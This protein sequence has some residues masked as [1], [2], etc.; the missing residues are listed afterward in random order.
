[1]PLLSA[2][3]PI[4]LNVISKTANEQKLNSAD[5]A[6]VLQAD[7]TATSAS[8]KPEVQAM[9]NEAVHI[10]DQA[11]RLRSTFTDDE[12]T[13]IRLAPLATTYYV[14]SASA[15]GVVG[16]TKE[17]LAAGDAM[18]TLVKDARPT[19]LVDVAFGSLGKL[20]ADSTLDKQSPRDSLVITL[21]AATAAVKA[22]SPADAKS[23]GD[24]L[25]A[26]S[27]KVA[28]ASREGGFLGIGGTRVSKEEEQAIA[29]I[30][31]AVA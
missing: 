28:E 19:S 20:D 15:S 2:V 13:K 4:M 5:I 22:K 16:T 14:M 26:L 8:A 10:G 21:Q 18:K 17:L 12:W 30:A 9:V 7:R 3:V 23:F 11:E 25:V 6:R 1:M 29:E 27:R 31:A 24:T